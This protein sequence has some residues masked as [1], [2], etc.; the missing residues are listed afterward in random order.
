MMIDLPN[1]RRT[2]PPTLAS[3][4]PLTALRAFVATARQLSFIGAAAELH[5]TSAAVGQQIRLLEDHLGRALFHR[6]RGQLHLTDAGREL[7]PGLTE[8]FD[9]VVESLARLAGSNIGAPIRISVAPSFASKW[10]I[11][12][13][14]TL[15]RAAPA[16][17]VQIDASPRLINLAGEDVD[18]VVRYGAG[19]YSDLA[20]DRLFGESVLPVCSPAFAAQYSLYGCPDALTEVPLLHE[21]GFERDPSCPDWKSWLRAEGLSPRLGGGGVGFSLSSLVL[22]AAA[23]GQGIGLA[24][25]RLAEA[26]L[27]AGRLVSPFGTP[28]PIEYAYFFATTPAKGKYPRV[29]I[30][31]DWLLAE[32]RAQQAPEHFIANTRT[33]QRPLAVVN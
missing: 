16:L 26:D 24:K 10:L 12:R 15:R 33:S 18:C 4:P 25:Y 27:A 23:A 30:F 31:R 32:A 28:R 22:D 7:M 21:D 2:A 19:G 11:P 17:E 3:L 9:G 29:K 8:A 14:E 1:R 6:D 20:T 5:V 13:L